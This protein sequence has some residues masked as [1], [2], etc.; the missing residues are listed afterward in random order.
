M[1]PRPEFSRRSK[2]TLI[3]WGEAILKYY[4]P[5]CFLLNEPFISGTRAHYSGN[6]GSANTPRSTAFTLAHVS[7]VPT[8][9]SRPS[10]T[11][12]CPRE[13]AGGSWSA[14]GCLGGERGR[15]GPPALPQVAQGTLFHLLMPLSRRRGSPSREN[16]ASPDPGQCPG[17]S[18]EAALLAPPDH[19]LLLCLPRSLER[20]L[21]FSL[22]GQCC[23]LPSA[24]PCLQGRPGL[25][26]SVLPPPHRRRL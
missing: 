15:S 20:A 22:L 11:P 7:L 3:L 2:L 1:F 24:V 13:I 4:L 23:P 14:L 17:A 18:S 9:S 10:Q 26:S 19:L 5:F 12:S 25:S 21:V 8:A 6:R 16:A